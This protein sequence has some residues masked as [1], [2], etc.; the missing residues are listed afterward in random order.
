[1]HAPNERVLVDELEGAVVAEAE[2]FR[3]YAA[4]KEEHR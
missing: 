1:L 2:F 4:R 3:E